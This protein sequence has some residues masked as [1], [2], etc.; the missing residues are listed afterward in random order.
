MDI[1]RKL[2]LK[3]VS[4]NGQIKLEET[5]VI[6]EHTLQVLIN[7]QPVY[8][9]IC[10]KDHLRELVTGR[11]VT[12]G[13]IKKKDDIYNIFFCKYENE[14]S[15]FLNSDVSFAETL[16]SVPT[17]CSGNRVYL[18]NE[19]GNILQKLPEYDLKSEWVFKLAEEFGHG[20]PV[21]DLTGASHICILSRKGETLFTGE[22]IGRHNAVDKAVGYAVLHEIPLSECMLF[23]SGRV[24]VDMV[25]KVIAAGIPVLVSKSVPTAESVELAEEY[26]LNLIGRAWP[27]QYEVFTASS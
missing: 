10:T 24:P 8:R 23:T 20:A 12:D 2:T 19:H 17:C 9:I 7:E 4:F 1:T 18:T 22:D 11:L 5:S 15:V 6:S 13:I 16:I 21:H 26:N 3:S 27:D 25:E 14:A